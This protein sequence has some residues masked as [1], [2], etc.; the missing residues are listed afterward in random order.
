MDGGQLSPEGMGR[1][2]SAHMQ[3]T[4]PAVPGLLDS[5][6]YQRPKEPQEMQEPFRHPVSTILKR[7]AETSTTI[8]S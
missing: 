1:K 2:F 5:L 4:F 6:R 7:A 3:L 8:Q